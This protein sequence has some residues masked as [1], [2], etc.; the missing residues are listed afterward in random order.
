MLIALGIQLEIASFLLTPECHS[1]IT[2]DKGEIMVHVRF[3]GRSYDV[4]ENQLNLTAGLSDAQLKERLAQHF[5]IS[6][7]RFCHYVVD[8]R[9]SGDTIVRPEAVYG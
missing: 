3:E 8:K 6:V 1:R 4:T 5:D 2:Q 9:P 7:N